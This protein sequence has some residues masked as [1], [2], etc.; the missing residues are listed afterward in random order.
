MITKSSLC[1][2]CTARAWR[3][4]LIT[5]VALFSISFLYAQ[6]TVDVVYLKNGSIIRGTIIQQAAGDK[7]KI[8]TA[9]G[10]V[11]VFNQD[12]VLK[13]EKEA[14]P[15][16]TTHQSNPQT[17]QSPPP[18]PVTRLTALAGNFTTSVDNFEEIYGSSSMWCFGGEGEIR[19]AGPFYAIVKFNYLSKSGLPMTIVTEGVTIN[20]A[21]SQW[22]QYWFVFGGK[23]YVPTGTAVSPFFGGGAG[24]FNIT[25]GITATVHANGNS[26][27][28]RQS[29]SK[30]NWGLSVFGGLSIQVS[31]AIALVGEGEFT[32]ASIGGGQGVA[33]SDVK[34][35]GFVASVGL[36]VG[37]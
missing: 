34:V 14:A 5:I 1:S 24:Y 32:S 30:N 4:A 33:G 12:E 15:Q 35:G 36:Q 11:F 19:L 2:A 27:K 25:E 37:F 23:M 8:Q 20:D 18:G 29:T 26:V 31:P 22:S 21:T 16:T 9:D 28:I 6:S 3:I 13:T 10:S 7:V 17:S